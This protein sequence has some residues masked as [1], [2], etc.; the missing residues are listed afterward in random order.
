MI[1]T[2]CHGHGSFRQRLGVGGMS[3]S[4]Q[5]WRCKGSGNATACPTC[6]GDGARILRDATTQ[7]YAWSECPD[8][9]GEGFLIGTKEQA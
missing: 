9:H 2:L 3:T 6:D 1:C 5:C 4:V 8:C 7:K